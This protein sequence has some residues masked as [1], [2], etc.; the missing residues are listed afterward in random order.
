MKFACFI[1]LTALCLFTASS[2]LAQDLARMSV[3]PRDIEI[4]ALYNGTALT[5]TGSIPVESEAIIRFVG[6][7][8]DL[9]MKEKGKAGGL[10]W[11]GLDSLTFK[12]APNV[13]LVSSAVDLDR[14]EATEGT[15]VKSLMLCGLENSIRIEA[16]R[17]EHK[18]AFKEFLKLKQKEGLYREIS[19]NIHYTTASE[20]QKTFRASI[21]VPSR[22]TP[23]PY[24]IEL[25]AVRNGNVTARAEQPVTVSLVGFP[26]LLA[27]LAFGFPALYGILAT[28]TAVLAG[29]IIGALFQSKSAH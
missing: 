8:C 2:A 13:C 9:H 20:G 10:L 15:S 6:A 14:L 5:V 4:G 12:G 16:S 17:G 19:G 25:A 28:L 1:L 24:V 7:S 3:E 23:G 18:D 26:A 29:L 11:M 21:P 22:L 27:R